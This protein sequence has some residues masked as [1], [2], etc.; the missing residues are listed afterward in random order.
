M[1]PQA[2]AALTLGVM[3]TKDHTVQGEDRDYPDV[4]PYTC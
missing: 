4:T 2:V 3:Q 1:P